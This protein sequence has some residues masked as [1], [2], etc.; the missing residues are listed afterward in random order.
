MATRSERELRKKLA[1]YPTDHLERVLL[2]M[3]E[4]ARPDVVSTPHDT[5]R[6]VAPLLSGQDREH[7]VAVF[8]NR[9]HRLLAVEVMS[10]G[11]PSCTVVDPAYILRRALLLRASC[12]LLAHNHP[13]GDPEP[14]RED[15]ASTARVGQAAAVVGIELLDHLVVAGEQFRSL[16]QMESMPRVDGYARTFAA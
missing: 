14:S 16:A 7:L 10:I 15:I 8:L 9:R 1:T 12:F 5:Y 6:V 4:A 3:E 13:S 2:A 11:G